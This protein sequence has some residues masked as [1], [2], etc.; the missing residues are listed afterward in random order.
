M[1]KQGFFTWL[2]GTLFAFFIGFSGIATLVSALSLAVSLWQVAL[3]CFASAMV[4]SFCCGR[5]L[6][7]V[8]VGIFGIALGI[9]LFNGKLF[10]SF[11]SLVYNLS[12]AYNTAFGWRVLQVNGLTPEKMAELLPIV[13]CFWG[14]LVCAVCAWSVTKGQSTVPV[15]LL[16]L[17][18]PLSGLI[19]AE[20]TP[21]MFW[22]FLLVYGLAMVL[23]TGATRYDDA[24]RGNRATLYAALPVALAVIIL[25][26]A[27]PKS[28]YT[29]QDRSKEWSDALLSRS[30]LRQAWDVLTGRQI[31]QQGADTRS[32]SLSDLGA[33]SETNSPVMSVLSHYSGMVYLRGS[34]LDTYDGRNW[35]N[36]GDGTT[37]SWPTESQLGQTGELMISTRYAHAMLYMPY[38]VTSMNLD[39]VARGVE[40]ETRMTQYSVT[41]APMP[42]AS[43]F[44]AL[45]PDPASN[46]HMVGGD[47]DTQCTLLPENTMNWAKPLAERITAGLGNNYHKALAI[48]RY[49]ETSATYSLR[50]AKMPGS[51]GDFARWFL[52]RADSGYCVHFATAA[53]VLLKAAGIPARYVVGYR[54]MVQEGVLT[55]VTDAHAH[56]W[57]EYWL[58]GFGW[59]VLD[60]TPASAAVEGE[61][62]T[63]KT[64]WT[65]SLN[66]PGGVW[67]GI[68]LFVPVALIAQWRIR[69]GRRLRRLKKGDCKEK[70]ISR[71]GRLT[72]LYELLGQE[73][74][75]DITALAEKAKFSPHPM[76]QEDVD[77]LDSAIDGAKGKLRRI[78]FFKR[79]YYALIQAKL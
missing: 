76:T 63:E 69:L 4:C 34:A 10:D 72:E 53:T 9:L 74:P 19:V 26:A 1:R 41:C 54:V 30:H 27:I 51:E 36:S 29:G 22:M 58:P 47:L 33:R 18:A 21:G 40:N 50:P 70:V 35:V 7:L 49:V 65:F 38:Y 44:E 61:T 16:A 67:I 28:T 62:E 24:K 31:E 11:R 43:Y 17:P 13:L 78:N 12:A 15:V 20:S 75:A 55:S 46:P 23:L 59:T 3:W 64:Q 71:Y 68:G 60:P 39:R 79:I 25:F 52:E 48:A 14:S 66:I 2:Q 6:G 5:R 77:T 45:Y 57:V 56:A 42:N 73:I 8:V 37:L 32:V